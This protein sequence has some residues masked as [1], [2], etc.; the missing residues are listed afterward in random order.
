MMFKDIAPLE[1]NIAM[2]NS[3]INLPLLRSSIIL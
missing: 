1:L 2:I 3:S